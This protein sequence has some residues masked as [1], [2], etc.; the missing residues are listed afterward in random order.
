MRKITN[1]QGTVTTAAEDE[2]RRTPTAVHHEFA[3][4]QFVHI[5]LGATGL[6]VVFPKTI[7]AVSLDEIVK[8]AQTALPTEGDTASKS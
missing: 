2:F 6:Q 7:V 3:P 8:L 5:G 1:L 4:G